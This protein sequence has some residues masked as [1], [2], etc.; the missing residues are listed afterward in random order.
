M[1]GARERGEG[2]A[3]GGGRE[4]RSEGEERRRNGDREGGK[5][6]GRYTEEDTGQYTV[7]SAH[8]N[9]NTALAI[10]TLDITNT[11]S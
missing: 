7:Y 6:Q 3:I 2:E 9:H 1:G 5:F 10:A 11:K 8:K 4:Q